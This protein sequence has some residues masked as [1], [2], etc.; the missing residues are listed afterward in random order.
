MYQGE[1][2][3]NSGGSAR[4]QPSGG[5]HSQYAIEAGSSL[6]ERKTKS[7]KHGDTFGVFDTNGD[8]LSGKDNPEGLYHLDT[9]YL[10]HLHLLLFGKRPMVLSSTVR[11]DN[12]GLSCDLTNPDIIDD[13]GKCLIENDRVHIR[14]S[15]FIW[16]SRCYEMIAVRN[17]DLVAHHLDLEIGFAADFADVFEVRGKHRKKRGKCLP[18]KVA[19]VGVV[20][21][22]EGLDD[23]RR[24]TGLRFH[25]QPDEL[26]EDRARW[27]IELGPCERCRIFLEISCD[28]E[29]PQAP[30]KKDFA[31]ALVAL[32]RHVRSR[33][34]RGVSI[35]TSN[36]I[37]NEAVER[38]IAD[39]YML[40]THKSEG[41][42]PYAGIPW[43]STA[44]GRDGIITA[45]ETLW[46][47]PT[48]AKGV[49]GFLADHQA[50]ECNAEEDAEPGKILHE[51]RCGEMA[52]T[53]E[54]PF[55]RYYGT[56]D[57]TPLFLMLAG[58]YFRRTGDQTTVHQIWPQI[59]AALNWIDEYGDRDGDGF[60]EYGRQSDK[61]LSNQG[62]KDS[63]DSI[64]H[65]DGTLAKAPIALVEVQGYVYAAWL[66]AADIAEALG[67]GD[68]AAKLREKAQDLRH[69]FDETF[70]DEQLGT[71]V[72]AL[73]GEKKPCRVRASNAGHALFTGIAFPERAAKVVQTLMDGHSFSG[74]GIRTLAS[75]EARYNPMS[76]H[77]GSVWP[78]DN[79]LIAAGFARYGFR[80][81]AARVFEGLFA[82][83]T[84]ID[85][86]RLPELFC[87]FP[88]QRG[89]GPTFYPVACSPQAWAAVAPL[90]LIESCLG[91]AFDPA[92]GRILFDR[93]LLPAF[94]EEITLTNLVIGEHRADIALR[95]SGSQVLVDV[96]DRTG[97]VRVVTTS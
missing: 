55:G 91:L 52:N 8:I 79:S 89:R 2:G 61:G 18:P 27:E 64:F 86:T 19:K 62:W 35:T 56:V 50:H 87:G 20:L 81:E 69:R 57:A 74:W 88:R 7:L 58:A 51:M 93:P 90:F 14:R 5:P 16:Q 44:F 48:I 71:Y 17:F 4:G 40:A 60:V 47:D 84:H 63:D 45:L 80:K 13:D 15:R 9:R 25:P 6:E 37:L 76:Y 29:A 49:L 22:Y 34:Q 94:V 36:E 85:V 72:L 39:L 43:F 70:F 28:R 53:G 30:L 41:P 26:S 77:D 65:A 96:L 23:K 92:D 75:T 11:S 42:Y 67:K 21:A 66:A 3:A 10:S 12:A 33:R 32:R 24:S 31:S 38:S 97:A 46:F 54:V 83:S 73:D 68:E 82:A 1:G 78:H 95:R 59:E